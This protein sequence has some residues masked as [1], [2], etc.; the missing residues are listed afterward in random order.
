MKTLPFLFAAVVLV[1]PAPPTIPAAPAAQLRAYWVD[2]FGPGLSSPSEIEQVVADVKAA[3]MNAIFAQVVRRAD[4]LCNRS[5]APRTEVG[6]APPPFDPLQTLIDRAHA[7]GLEVHAWVI[8]T[9]MWREPGAPAPPG[10]AFTAH[11][12]TAKGADYWLDVRSDGTDH[13]ADEF[14][15]DPGHPDAADYMVRV[16]TSIVANYDVD[17]LNLD[18]IRYP[19]GNLATNVNSW[20]YNPTALA[21]FQAATRRSDRPAP[22]DAQWTQWRR[23]QIT[24]LVRKIYLESYALNPRVRV[25]AD[26]ITSGAGP[27][28]AGGWEKTRAYAEVLQDWRGWLG[29][30]ILDLNVA[31]DYKSDAVPAQGRWFAEW[32]QFT[33]DSQYRRAGAVGTALYL[34]AV[35]GSVRQ[36]REALAPSGAGNYGA[37]W[38]GYSYRTPDALVN[39]G[40]RDGTASREELTR[41]LTQ[42]SALDSIEPP[43]FARP[44][45]VPAM[46]WKAHP[47][48]GHISGTVR[49][50]SGAPLADGRVELV[51]DSSDAVVRAQ[52]TDTRGWFGFVDLAPGRY[53]VRAAS[54]S[55]KTSLVAGRLAWL[56][57]EPTA[58]S[59]PPASPRS[60]A[61]GALCGVD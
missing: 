52:T 8:V 53:R 10:H 38:V 40:T 37:G 50:A 27:E 28:S 24:S 7:Q 19:D 36:V 49:D 54:A 48:T 22:S 59:T 32:S 60:R 2:A 56:S 44:A 55:V 17:G 4:C 42:P 41:A 58:A 47:T 15:F 6:I 25:S 13:L 43:V 12:P 23:D 31:M 33:K 21:R 57:L 20:G 14:M 34:N 9:G 51:D 5:V 46:P 26:T 35:D 45:P 29:E 18:R 39:A 61:H 16:A 11:G 3:N 1:V 30:G